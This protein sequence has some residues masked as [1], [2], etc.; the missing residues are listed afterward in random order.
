MFKRRLEKQ[1]TFGYRG[2]YRNRRNYRSHGDP[3]NLDAMTLGRSSR[4]NSRGGG[5]GRIGNNERDRCRREKLCYTCGKSG[6]RAKECNSKPKRLYMINNDIAG[7]I[8]KKAD[9]II[10][11]GETNVKKGASRAQEERVLDGYRSPEQNPR[12]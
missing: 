3:I 9:T 11:A 6:H 10:N 5:R 8:V 7:I 12:W 4:P 2:G 1:G